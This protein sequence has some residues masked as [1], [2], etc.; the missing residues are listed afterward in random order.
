[1]MSVATTLAPVSD[2]IF[3]TAV[4]TNY[5][6]E[7]I[8]KGLGIEKLYT[9]GK[10]YDFHRIAKNVRDTTIQTFAEGEVLLFRL[11]FV[12]PPSCFYRT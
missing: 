5:N 11:V 9:L 4:A 2:R 10:L 3:S 8:T 7:K 6:F 1:M 12:A